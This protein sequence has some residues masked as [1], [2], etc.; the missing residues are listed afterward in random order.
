MIC[1]GTLSSKPQDS[2]NDLLGG[3]GFGGVS[4]VNSAGAADADGKALDGEAGKLGMS[5]YGCDKM[6]YSLS[7]LSMVETLPLYCCVQL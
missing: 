6:Q 3:I 1:V 2:F 4:S 7:L 5:L